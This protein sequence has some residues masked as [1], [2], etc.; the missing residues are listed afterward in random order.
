MKFQ[1]GHKFSRGGK[2]GN[3]G[4]RPTKFEKAVREAA[5]VRTRNFI[6]QY[7]EP[8][9]DTYLKLAKGH[10]VTVTRINK[11][12]EKIIT[13]KLEVDPA[14]TR[15]YIERL[16]PAA[17]QAMDLAVGTP[18]EFYQAIEQAKRDEKALTKED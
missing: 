8:V 14:T 2:K 16:V 9:L 1:K 11:K 17:R 13:R 4:G 7:L 10:M 15:H 5:E 3:K 6:D 18:E 12:G